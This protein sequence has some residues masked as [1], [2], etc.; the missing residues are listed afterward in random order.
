MALRPL[1][2]VP[3]TG[4]R[5]MSKDHLQAQLTFSGPG[6]LM[7]AISWFTRLS[8]ISLRLMRRAALC[9]GCCPRSLKAMFT[10]KWSST[11]PRLTDSL[12]AAETS[13]AY[14]AE[15][16]FPRSSRNIL[17]LSESSLPEGSAMLMSVAASSAV[18]L[19]RNASRS[20]SETL[21]CLLRSWT[22]S[23]CLCEAP[24]NGISA[25]FISLPFRARGACRRRRPRSARAPR[26]P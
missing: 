21:P 17:C 14:L 8:R 12:R 25:I 5:G 23:F 4:F 15:L 1:Y 9:L 24:T 7:S 18:G 10:K 16:G 19:A 13:G 26:S 6:L 11:A 22:F 20:A 3:E 2:L